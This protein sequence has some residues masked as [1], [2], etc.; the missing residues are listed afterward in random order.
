MPSDDPIG[1]RIAQLEAVYHRR[2]R[3]YGGVQLKASPEN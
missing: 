1:R 3:T 2:E